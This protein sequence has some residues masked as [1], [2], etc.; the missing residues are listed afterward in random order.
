MSINRLLN[1]PLP[2]EALLAL[3]QQGTA[4]LSVADL[5][6][7]SHPES[8]KFSCN[9]WICDG[10]AWES[11]RTADFGTELPLGQGRLTDPGREW[12]L[13]DVKLVLWHLKETSPPEAAGRRLRTAW[14][15]LRRLAA[16]IC[17]QA[18]PD[19]SF[20]TQARLWRDGGLDNPDSFAASLLA[21][22]GGDP[23]RIAPGTAAGHLN[24]ATLIFRAHQALSALGR[25]VM[26]EIPYGYGDRLDLAMEIGRKESESYR[27]MPDE[28][29]IP[30]L[31][32][33]LDWLGP[34]AEDVIAATSI[35]MSAFVN[36]REVDR[37]SP[38][39]ARKRAAGDLAAFRFSRLPGESAPW[40]APIFELV[41][42]KKPKAVEGGLERLVQL[43]RMVQTAALTILQQSSGMRADELLSLPAGRSKYGMPLC[44]E[45]RL[46]AQNTK[47]M[48]V[49]KGSISKV[50]GGLREPHDFVVG[51]RPAIRGVNTPEPPARRAVEVLLELGRQMRKFRDISPEAGNALVLI[52]D[53]HGFPQGGRTVRRM[54]TS[55]LNKN[56][57]VFLAEACGELLA[58][59]PD[60][61]PSLVQDGWLGQ[62]RDS[63]GAILCSTMIRKTF[64]NFAYSAKPELL[65]EIRVQYGHVS[66]AMTAC[67]ANND[68]QIL[69]ANAMEAEMAIGHVLEML[70]KN[71]LAGR[72][73][74]EIAVR[75]D[76]QALRQRL[77][78]APDDD[79]AGIVRDWLIAT[80][81][82]V[83]EGAQRTRVD[84]TRFKEDLKASAISDAAH[85]LCAAVSILASDQECRKAGGTINRLFDGFGPDKR[86]RTPARCTGCVN[87]VV[88][89]RHRPFW[90]Q[91][92]ATATET[93][94][95]CRQSG[96][97][98]SVYEAP[99]A[100]AGQARAWLA[101]IGTAP[102]RIA[103]LEARAADRAGKLLAKAGTRPRRERRL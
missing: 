8:G 4:T 58:A 67:Y 36:A 75:S 62:W 95:F 42:G 93:V 31:N 83:D 91:R 80:R 17:A 103:E 77:E 45:E 48:L 102:E 94:E 46:V 78:H 69:Q 16:W 11:E 6:I 5:R 44:L 43:W 92:L 30:L 27:P 49:L 1:A 51:M 7:S 71:A 99:Q 97:P 85:G 23:D 53:S 20:L 63:L 72:G 87:F 37:L 13:L 76:W 70:A 86:Y 28:V 59:L 66:E 74:E 55:T 39:G 25:P 82:M 19:F 88:L 22:L 9:V 52:W 57:R 100:T 12:L 24:S 32:A 79:A 38:G 3:G 14:Q 18:L 29:A 21:Q 15:Y 10:T 68:Y 81:R 50:N 64:A 47:H 26:P 98:V 60:D 33:A 61:S 65:P 2:P 35:Y 73:A 96:D 40:Q 89:E 54:Q 41:P 84:G 90:E 101:A 56:Y 34:R